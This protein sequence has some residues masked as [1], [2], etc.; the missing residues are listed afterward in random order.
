MAVDIPGLPG[1]A[2]K[3]KIVSP[4]KQSHIINLGNSRSEELYGPRQKVAVILSSQGVVKST[5]DLI[6]IK[7][8]KI[9]LGQSFIQFFRYSVLPK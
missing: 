6:R 4:G 2:I 5:A 9:H 3:L 8:G 1:G 7:F